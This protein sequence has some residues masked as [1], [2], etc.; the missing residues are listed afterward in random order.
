MI[1]YFSHSEAPMDITL[2]LDSITLEDI[3][4]IS[5]VTL[6]ENKK[7]MQNMQ[8]EVGKTITDKNKDISYFRDHSEKLL[9]QINNEN[10]FLEK[11]DKNH[12][13]GVVVAIT[14]RV[15]CFL[16][17]PNLGSPHPKI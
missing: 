12:Q 5:K 4:N 13:E 15:Y 2:E 3:K 10:K 7:L 8:K 11:K 1:W 14:T 6:Q 16:Q 9:M 17:E